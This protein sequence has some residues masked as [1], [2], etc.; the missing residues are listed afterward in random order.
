MS[1]FRQI[2]SLPINQNTIAEL[3]T[4]YCEIN[5]QISKLVSRELKCPS[6]EQFEKRRREYFE[7]VWKAM[8]QF[9]EHEIF[10]TDMDVPAS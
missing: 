2:Q 9:M 10:M 1:I 8:N 6:R 5:V 4:Y 7:H 3:L